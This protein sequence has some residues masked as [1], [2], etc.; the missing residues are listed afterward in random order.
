MIWLPIWGVEK[1]FRRLAVNDSETALRFVTFLREYRPLQAKLA[2]K[3]AHAACAGHWLHAPLSFEVLEP[4]LIENT[5]FKPSETWLTQLQALREQLIAY[6]H[7]TQLSLCKETFQAFQK[8]LTAFSA[9]TLIEHR[10][11]REE[12]L[13]ALQRWEAIASE[14]QR[15]LEE[16]AKQQEPI[17]TNVYLT[18]D[19]LHPDAN[20]N[21]FFGREDLK[22]E[23][24]RKVHAAQ[25][26]PLFLIQGQRRVGKTSLLKFLEP[27]L[28]SG[29]KVVYQDLQ[30][31][32]TG[33]VQN[34]LTDLQQKIH[35]K[36]NLTLETQETQ[37]SESSNWL[38]A[39][40][41]FETALK[42]LH[43]N[44]H[45]KLIL[46][47]DEY[48][49]LHELL[50]KDP[51]QGARLLGAM[52][53]FSQ[54]QNK[55]VFLFVGAALFT[56][57]ENPNWGNYFVQVQSFRVDYLEPKDCKR[58]ITEPVNLVYPDELIEQMVNLTQGHPA[59]LQLLCSEMV[60][61]ANKNL[62]RNMNQADLD[63]VIQKVLEDS[64]VAP[65]AVFWQQF[66]ENPACKATVREIIHSQ[67]I[68]DKKQLHR[69]REHGFIVQD[70]AGIWRLRV[71]LFER[72]LTTFERVDLG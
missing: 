53:S 68:S 24:S 49:G 5:E 67:S 10:S 47:F 52:R 72:W 44:H 64:S 27:M 15:H 58:L 41:N 7:Q 19:A 56:E 4:P 40:E 21:I 17:T 20:E 48:E 32:Q 62:R 45:Y 43:L 54:H 60:N 3:I 61:Q 8:Q 13:Q 23:F 18:G 51:E 37:H 55:I 14:E 38:S 63:S 35:L 11:W 30:G 34:W 9:Q 33:S 26:M 66:C 70:S 2:D 57:L 39:W 65:M 1:Q 25:Q 6:R 12:Y 22:E 59:L 16:F 36:L 29:F 42:S 71:P 46:A 50:Q 31:A 28:G 69:L